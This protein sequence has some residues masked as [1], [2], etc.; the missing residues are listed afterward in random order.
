VV[1]KIKPTVQV[2]NNRE[3]RLENNLAGARHPTFRA[4]TLAMPAA[5]R[6]ALD[7]SSFMRRLV[8]NRL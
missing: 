1:I 5:S 8:E 4:Q 7:M 6:G 2:T 3:E